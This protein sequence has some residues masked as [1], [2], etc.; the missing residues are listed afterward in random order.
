MKNDPLTERDLRT[1]L[2]VPPTFDVGHHLRELARVVLPAL[3]GAL[4]VAGVAYEAVSAQPPQYQNSVTAK[5]DS[6]ALAGMTDVTVNTLAPP[7]VALS[8]SQ[9]VLED[10][11]RRADIDTS[12]AELARDVD[13][14]VQVSPSLVQVTSR[15]PTADG[16]I[17]LSNAMVSALDE[18]IVNVWID[19]VTKDAQD[20]QNSAAD[21]ATKMVGLDPDSPRY[22]V[23]HADFESQ[24]ARA[25]QL[26]AAPPTRIVLLSQ[27]GVADKVAPLPLRQTG[28]VFLAS[29]LIL[30]ELFAFLNG[31]IGRRTNA[32][33]VRR[34]AHRHGYSVVSADRGASDWP[35]DTQ[36]LLN[37][38]GG[39]GPGVLLLRSASSTAQVYVGEA[40]SRDR[41]GGGV[42]VRSVGSDW[43]R[44]PEAG[45]HPLAIAVIDARGRDRSAWTE[46]FAALDRY[47]IPVQ[48]VVLGERHW[49]PRRAGRPAPAEVEVPASEAVEESVDEAS[50]ARAYPE[51]AMVIGAGPGTAA[52]EKGDSVG[53]RNNGHES[54]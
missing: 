29:L 18:A 19:R 32:A 10:A 51:Y 41:S 1:R 9:A 47:G 33:W 26:R 48:L 12:P 31:R 25:Q 37:T 5:I 14:S 20:L 35:L 30:G 42:E 49:W 22:L 39:H 38:V 40:V 6:G 52:E 45:K 27:P 44:D 23:L 3:L 2:N 16:A 43:W 34:R 13:V 46:A 36:V 17:Q 24:L 15:A 28:V 53:A 21:S 54:T 8:K 7:F 4:V 11:A 50:P